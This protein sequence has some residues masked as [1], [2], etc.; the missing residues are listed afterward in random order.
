MS[1]Y[2]STTFRG[3]FSVNKVLLNS[4]EGHR[5]GGAHQI[6]AYNP[7]SNQPVD[8]TLH[9][10]GVNVIA[11]QENDCVAIVLNGI[12]NTP[13]VFANPQHVVIEGE[14]TIQAD[15]YGVL[16]DGQA[17]LNDTVYDANDG[18]IKFDPASTING[19]ATLVTFNYS[20]E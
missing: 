6:Y 14:Y 18:I 20:Q 16:V 3:L 11:A 13:A 4:G 2:G 8:V 7:T 15:T 9:S 12:A 17:T 19:N 10:S 1:Y 5:F